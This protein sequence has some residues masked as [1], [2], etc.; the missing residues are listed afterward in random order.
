MRRWSHALAMVSMAALAVV[1]PGAVA[2]HAATVQPLATCSGLSCDNH[3][4]IA[5]GCSTSVA[6]VPGSGTQ[7]YNGYLEMRYGN[8]QTNWA[9]FTVSDS[10][11]Y[12]IW[13]QRQ[14]ASGIPATEG[15][16]Y[17]FDGTAAAGPYWSD[18]LY[19]PNSPLTKARVCVTKFN[20]LWWDVATC[21]PYL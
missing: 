4:P 9:R 8:C 2:A 19:A 6:T 18:Q 10:G 7:V 21:T 16:H 13:V 5:T 15:N 11:H 3:D 14:A 1:G 12:G 20:G 17:D